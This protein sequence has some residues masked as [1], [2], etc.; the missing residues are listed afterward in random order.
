LVLGDAI[1]YT[2]DGNSHAIF[3]GALGS[4]GTAIYWNDG[5]ESAADVFVPQGSDEVKVYDVNDPNGASLRYR[6]IKQ[7]NGW[8]ADGHVAHVTKGKLRDR[9]LYTNY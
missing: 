6:H 3:W 1:Q 7:I 9:N 2:P 5:L 4:S 8:F